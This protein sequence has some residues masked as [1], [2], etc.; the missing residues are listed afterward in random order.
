MSAAGDGQLRRL[1]PDAQFVNVV[2]DRR[3]TTASLKRMAWYPHGTES[4]MSLWSLAADCAVHDGRALPAD[5]WHE[6]VYERLVAEPESEL[7]RL[8]E[9]LGPGEPGAGGGEGH[10]RQGRLVP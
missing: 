6:V 5:A 1:F 9:F 7:R 3:D 2:R 4:A 8:C 10:D